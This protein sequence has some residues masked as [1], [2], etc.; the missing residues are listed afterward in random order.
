MYMSRKN[1]FEVNLHDLRFRDAFRRYWPQQICHR[2]RTWKLYMEINSKGNSTHNPNSSKFVLLYIR[3]GFGAMTSVQQV[4][5][6]K[7][8]ILDGPWHGYL[9]RCQNLKRQDLSLV[10]TN[11]RLQRL[12]QRARSLRKIS[13]FTATDCY[14]CW[15]QQIHS[16]SERAIRITFYGPMSHHRTERSKTKKHKSETLQKTDISCTMLINSLDTSGQAQA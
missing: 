14:S 10:D 15:L 9:P 4:Y 5:N 13:I 16:Q 3:K 12:S 2:K 6:L 11:R 1:Y 7:N 8:R